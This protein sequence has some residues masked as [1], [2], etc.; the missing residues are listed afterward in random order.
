LEFPAEYETWLAGKSPKFLCGGVAFLTTSPSSIAINPTETIKIHNMVQSETYTSDLHPQAIL[1]LKSTASATPDPAVDEDEEMHFF[2][3]FTFG[4]IF[5]TTATALKKPYSLELT[6]TDSTEESP[7]RRLRTV[8]DQDLSSAIPHY[9]YI[10]TVFDLIRNAVDQWGDKECLGTRNL[11]QQHIEQKQV[12][13]LINGVE[14]QV[15]KTWVYS[16]LSS[17]QYRSYEDLG[18]ESAAVGAG[19]RNL[20]LEP[21]DKVGLYAETSYSTSPFVLI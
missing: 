5:A 2:K 11:V 17:F 18:T 9:P 20:G 10:L 19:L 1:H 7:I 16:E 8:I 15:N 6:Q 21:G 12:T 14:Q 4:S 13:K 3:I